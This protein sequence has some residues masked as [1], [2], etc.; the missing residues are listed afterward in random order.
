MKK[1]LYIFTRCIWTFI[2]FRYQLVNSIDKNKFNVYVCLDFDGYKKNYLEKKY[3]NITFINIKF[4]NKKNSLI[5]NFRI[6]LSIFKVFYNNKIHIAH[7]FTARPIV[8]VSLISFFFYRT[9]IINTITGLGNNF[10]QN[11]LIYKLLYNFLFLKSLIVVFQNHQDKNIIFKFLRK[12]I[13]IKIIYPTV[14]YKNNYKIHSDKNKKCVF[15]MHSRMI[16]Q[17][18][19]LEYIDA[20]KKIDKNYRKKSTFYLIG[21]PDKNNPSSIPNSYLNKLSKGNVLRYMKHKNNI[22]KYLLKSDVIILPSYGEGLP[23]S[24]LEALFFRKAIITT[25]VNGCL[26]VIKDNYNGIVVNCKNSNEIYMA[27]IKILDNPL[28]LRKFKN[29]S[30]K[31]Y[32][33]KFS[34]NTIQE[35]LDI[36]SHYE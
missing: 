30:Y 35:Y 27:I 19:V 10:F 8:F 15:L 28:L 11:N 7:N 18:G 2:N 26:E 14:K 25:R 34:K 12:R 6:L 32:K 33:K 22:N 5:L 1:N 31:L 16:K 3:K 24:L 29:N 21:S 13:R 4:L 23:A 17:K 9:K 36:Y 20:V